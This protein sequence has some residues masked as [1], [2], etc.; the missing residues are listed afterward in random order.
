MILPSEAEGPPTVVEL[1]V[2][3]TQAALAGRR[4]T[5]P[6]VLDEIIGTRN[7]DANVVISGDQVPGTHNKGADVLTGPGLDV[8]AVIVR[9][10]R[11]TGS[12]GADVVRID[13]VVRRG[14]PK[15]VDP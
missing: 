14:G 6:I 8:H 9:D 4:G 10:R 12:V 3:Y 15:D 5:D 1:E 13:G 2:R 7:T 11:C